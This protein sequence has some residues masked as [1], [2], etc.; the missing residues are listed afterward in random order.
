[1]IAAAISSHQVNTRP[2]E[3]RNTM[4]GK[5]NTQQMNNQRSRGQSLIEFA[6]VLPMLL[7]L[8]LGAMDFGRMFYTKIVIT[9]AARE[10]ANYISRNIDDQKADAKGNKYTN[11][12][13]IIKA[14]ASSSGI[15]PSMLTL[16]EPVNCCEIGQKVGVT[17]ELE[18]LNLFFSNFY[19]FLSAG[20]PITLSS[21]VWMVVQ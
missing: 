13:S 9:N 12:F 17:V 5:K 19:E 3:Q 15:D 11:T 1:M 4:P 2:R 16:N 14:E 21:T 7:V 20:E 6:L 18:N 10:G 8:I